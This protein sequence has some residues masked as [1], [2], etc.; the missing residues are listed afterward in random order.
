MNN[1]T[2]KKEFVEFVYKL[3]QNFYDD[4]DTWENIDIGSFLESL[5]AWVEDME[6]YYRNEGIEMPEV[7]DWQMI[8]NMLIA[9]KVYE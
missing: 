6:G 9:G 5:G 1:I 2:T 4:P 8:A 7:P 3:S